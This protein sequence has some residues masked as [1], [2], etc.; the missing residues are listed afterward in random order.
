MSIR[1]MRY[2]YFRFVVVLSIATLLSLSAFTI[3]SNSLYAVSATQQQQERLLHRL[4][5]AKGE[6]I[7]ITDIKV[8]EQIV[9]FDQ[10][11]V[12]DDNWIQRTVISVKNR[13]DKRILYFSVDFFFPPPPGSQSLLSVFNLSYGNH[14]LLWDHSPTPTERLIGLAPGET[15]DIYLNGRQYEN[16]RRFIADIGNPNAKRVDLRFSHIIFEDDT[17]WDMQGPFWRD[18]KDPSKWIATEEPPSQVRSA[19]AGRFLAS[20]TSAGGRSTPNTN[21]R[22]TSRFARQWLSSSNLEQFS[23]LEGLLV[24]ASYRAARVAPFDSPSECYRQQTPTWQTCSIGAQCRTPKDLTDTVSGGF[25]FIQ[26]NQI[27]TDVMGDSCGTGL[28]TIATQC[29]FSGGGGGGEEGDPQC[30]PHCVDEYVCLEGEVCGYSPILIDVLGN[31]FRLTDG[32]GGVDFDFDDDGVAGRLSWTA[33]GSDDAWLVLDR[34]D[35]GFIDGGSELFGSTTLQP[36]PPAG[37]N[38]NG[39]LA[40]AEFDRSVNGGNRD[41]RIDKRD[42]V[43]QFLQLWQDTN[44]DGVS[45]SSEMHSLL[46]LNVKAID[47]EYK[48]SR[49]VDEYGNQFKYRAKVYDKRGASVGR[50]AW[51]VFLVKP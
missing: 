7:V 6:P 29:I 42:A 19:R 32:A 49:K 39:F 21:G 15:A 10:K 20:I 34:N 44:H 26:G 45:E 2:S 1:R 50:W 16:F 22:S 4:P 5:F 37:E 40:L 9:S 12:A 43:F 38:K 8:N 17:M 33:P 47:L 23:Q 27:C 46:S 18:P 30:D 24:P 13:S 25:K 51:D 31:G 14:A 28:T 41:G 36:A 3:F 48:Q 35:N 11:F